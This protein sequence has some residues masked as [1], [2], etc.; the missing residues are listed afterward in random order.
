V[1]RYVLPILLPQN[2]NINRFVEESYSGKVRALAYIS[3][4]GAAPKTPY[5]ESRENHRIYYRVK[6]DGV[7]LPS[8]V[9]IFA[10]QK[11]SDSEK[12]RKRH[13]WAVWTRCSWVGMM[14]LVGTKVSVHEG[15]SGHFEAVTKRS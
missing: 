5:G 2:E 11:T 7:E 13:P 14:T 4:T 6:A 3:S 10:S 15:I 1:I 12:E 8:L 9:C